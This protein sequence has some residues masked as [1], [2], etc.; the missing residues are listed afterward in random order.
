MAPTTQASAKK[1]TAKR[2]VATPDSMSVLA[3]W[4]NSDGARG[5][6]GDDNDTGDDAKT[7]YARG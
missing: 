5:D 3:K 6:A 7:D 4:A 2:K 1:A